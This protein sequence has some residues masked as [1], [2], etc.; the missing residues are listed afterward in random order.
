M[1]LVNGMMTVRNPLIKSRSYMG[2]VLG[3][4]DEIGKKDRVIYY[5]SKKFTNYDTRYP[6]AEKIC[7]ALGWTV[8]R[9]Q[10]YMLC[11]DG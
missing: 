7:C 2:C 3:K 5:L 1:I 4:H 6:S 8:R 9:L 11:L 10:Q